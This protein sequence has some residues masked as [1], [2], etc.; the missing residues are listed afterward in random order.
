[1]AAAVLG[2]LYGRRRMFMLG[3]ILFTL[4][5]LACG[6]AN[7]G[8]FL[9][10][11][12]A[13]QGISAAL[14]APQVLAI[15]RTVYTGAAQRKVF[16]GYGLAMGLAAVFGQ[17]IGGLLIQANIA[18]LGWR[19]CFLVNLPI[20]VLIL[21]LTWRFVPETRA[22][23]RP[24]LDITGVVLVTVALVALVLPLIE[25]REEHWP[26]WT[27]LSLVAAIGLFAVFAVQESRVSARGGSP[28]VE[29]SLFKERAFVVGL[30]TQMVFWT[31]QA[32]FF[33]VFALY[34]QS[35]RGL[36]A[37]Q[38]G[39]IFAAIGAGYMY[40]SM[41]AS[42]FTV[43]LGRQVI[44]IGAVLMAAGLVMLGVAVSHIGIGGHIGWLI[45]GLVLDGAGMGLAVA[46]LAATVLSRISPQHVGAASGVLTTSMQVG[47][48]VGV[49]VVGIIFYNA[50]GKGAYAHAFNMSLIFLVA[51]AIT[52]AGLVQLLPR[53][54]D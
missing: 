41:N 51:V 11:A 27:W 4:T 33:L 30:S 17:L 37:L 25:G 10:A 46:P 39:L 1:M 32:S 24:K 31:G 16:N 34:T 8:E 12:R 54:K 22:A 2:D 43:R 19:S 35:G 38:A 49:A 7:T 50:L 45:P 13:A 9:V 26:L 53:G 28:L 6:V 5:S 20:G 15:L 29:M 14:L 40:T 42:K 47:N 48:A 23:N 44:A 3:L 21:A 18:G 36:D 52:L